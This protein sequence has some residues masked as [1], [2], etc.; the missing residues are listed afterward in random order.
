MRKRFFILG[1]TKMIAL[2]EDCV[3]NKANS[4]WYIKGVYHDEK[5]N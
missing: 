2:F 1:N 4:H 5:R 3:Y